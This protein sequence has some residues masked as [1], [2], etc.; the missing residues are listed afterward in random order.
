MAIDMHVFVMSTKTKRILKTRKD[1]HN[2]ATFLCVH[3]IHF[4]ITH[5]AISSSLNSSVECGMQTVL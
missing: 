3:Q 5:K 2:H 4:I 1:L